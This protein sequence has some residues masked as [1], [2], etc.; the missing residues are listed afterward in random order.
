MAPEQ[1]TAARVDRRSDVYSL[2]VVLYE[3]LTDNKP[4]DGESLEEIRDAVQ[5]A[6]RAGAPRVAQDPAGRW[7]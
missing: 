1:M 4:F 2:G 3:L 6:S 7:R 5:T